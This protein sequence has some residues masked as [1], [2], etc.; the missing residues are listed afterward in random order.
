MQTRLR[1][2]LLA[3]TPLALLSSGRTQEK[4]PPF[5]ITISASQAVKA[6]SAVWLGIAVKNISGSR[7]DM[8]MASGVNFNFLFSVRHLEGNKAPETPLYDAIQGKEPHTSP[9]ISVS[10]RWSRLPT[11]L[12]PGET[13]YFNTDVDRLFELKP[14]KYTIQLSRPQGPGAAVEV[15][16]PNQSGPVITSNTINLTVTP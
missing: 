14:G 2:C 15:Q 8:E 11:W 1:W 16:R 4:Q 3:V 9:H 6:G 12:S 7:I 10:P 5:S 13:L